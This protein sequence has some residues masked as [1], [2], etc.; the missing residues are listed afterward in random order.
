[1]GR[2]VL[3]IVT[4]IGGISTCV[5]TSHIE[6]MIDDTSIRIQQLKTIISTT[7]SCSD[8]VLLGDF[9]YGDGETENKVA[10]L[11]FSD[12]WKILKVDSPGYTWDIN[13][14]KLAKENSFPLEGSRRLDRIYI[15]GKHLIPVDIK[16]I[17]DTPFQ[18]TSGIFLFPS[19][20]FGLSAKFA[21][22]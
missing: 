5:A 9:N 4:N 20:H 19:D 17:G 12:V 14:S 6:S 2:G 11:H 21:I 3:S 10:D 15:K 7:S 18:S 1:M 8:L 16:I 13:R 22:Q